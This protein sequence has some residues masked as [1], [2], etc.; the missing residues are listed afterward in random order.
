MTALHAP[1]TTEQVAALNAYQ[2]TGAFHPFTCTDPDDLHPD[3]HVLL[4]AHQDG[5]HCPAADCSYAQDWVHPDMVTAGQN[6]PMPRSLTDIMRENWRRDEN[7]LKAVRAYADGALYAGP[8]RVDACGVRERL[9]GILNGTEDCDCDAS[10]PDPCSGRED[11][12]PEHIGGNAEDCPGCTAERVELE[13]PWI[14]PKPP[15]CTCGRTIYSLFRD[16]E[17]FGSW[18]H[19]PRGTSDEACDSPTNASHFGHPGD[20]ST[21]SSA[22]CSKGRLEDI[23]WLKRPIHHCDDAT[24]H[25]GHPN[26]LL[27]RSTRCPG[28]PKEN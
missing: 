8:S 1:W 6:K 19:D 17:T 3:D 16:G 13:Y 4:V 24:P 9:L 21:K 11:I 28:T 10:T 22:I 27:N 14:C 23:S 25:P 5:W 7:R 2:F 18:V 12:I 26:D 15:R 20:C